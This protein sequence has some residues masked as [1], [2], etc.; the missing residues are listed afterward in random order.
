MV[1]TDIQKACKK[2]NLPSQTDEDSRTLRRAHKRRRN[3]HIKAGF[4]PEHVMT[5]NLRDQEATQAGLAQLQEAFGVPA[6]STSTD[7]PTPTFSTSVDPNN[8]EVP[9]N[10]YEDEDDP[11]SLP[12]GGLKSFSGLNFNQAL[13]NCTATIM[14]IAELPPILN[15]V[16]IAVA[17]RVAGKAAINAAAKATSTTPSVTAPSKA[18]LSVTAPSKAT[19]SKAAPSKAAPSKVAPSKVAPSKVA[20]SK[21]AS[22]KVTPKA[23]SFK[24]AP[25][26]AAPKAT[27]IVKK[28]A[29]KPKKLASVPKKTSSTVKAKTI[30]KTRKNKA[31]K[32]TKK[33]PVQVESES[34]PESPS[35]PEF[36]PEEEVERETEKEIVEEEV[37]IEAEEVVERDDSDTEVEKPPKKKRRKSVK[38]TEV[39]ASDEETIPTLKDKGKRKASPILRRS[40]RSSVVDS[41][42]SLSKKPNTHSRK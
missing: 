16:E 41:N 34:E 36:E 24:T 31:S 42:T 5:L 8:E 4:E 11:D 23:A 9:I 1:L 28:S 17:A 38:S 18:A 32:T 37:E 25:S 3:D 14:A 13:E 10:N 2:L 21:A 15:K 26:K 12:R 19:P 33:S 6:S 35:E 22:S 39:V 30:S 29:P 7:L 40:K 27:P 20:P